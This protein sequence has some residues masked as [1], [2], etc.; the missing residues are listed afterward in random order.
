MLRLSTIKRL[1]LNVKIG[2]NIKIILKLKIKVINKK[3]T[4]ATTFFCN[5]G[6]RN[7]V[8]PSISS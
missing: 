5:I 3:E 8:D 6:K 1:I 2:E 7:N 4:K